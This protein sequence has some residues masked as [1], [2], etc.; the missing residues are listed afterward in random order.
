[1]LSV[2]AVRINPLPPAGTDAAKL[3]CPL[4]RKFACHALV[5]PQISM[6]AQAVSLHNIYAD[7]YINNTGFIKGLL[8]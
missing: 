6:N 7:Q 2:I 4:Y 3:S 5:L 8:N 1:M